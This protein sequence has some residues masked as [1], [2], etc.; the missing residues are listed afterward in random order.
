MNGREA[1][2]IPEPAAMPAAPPAALPTV[3]PAA[4]QEPAEAPR[5]ATEPAAR[6]PVA[7]PGAADRESRLVIVF[8]FA[9]VL[10]LLLALVL[11]LVTAAQSV[12][13]TQAVTG[14]AMTIA[15][16]WHGDGKTAQVMS[17]FGVFVLAITVP[18]RR[19]A[20]MFWITTAVLFLIV[21]LYQFLVWQTD[22]GRWI[23]NTLTDLSQAQAAQRIAVLR[24]LFETV[25]NGALVL[26]AAMLGL[27]VNKDAK[28]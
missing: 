8:F 9:C 16:A 11:L 14:F 17:F 21:V 25:R 20:A 27:A 13:A 6:T 12:V 18:L 5:A 2:A 23:F 22:P 15:E 3:V 1:A 10:V 7:E 28:N 4:A 24:D 19:T 26:I